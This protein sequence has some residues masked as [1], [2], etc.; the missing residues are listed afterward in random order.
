MK[1]TVIVT[2]AA[3]MLAGISSFSLAGE[4]A[5][6]SVQHEH[7]AVTSDSAQSALNTNKENTPSSQPTK[8]TAEHKAVAP[9]SMN[10][11]KPEEPMAENKP[12]ATVSDAAK[13]TVNAVSNQAKETVTESVK[14]TVPTPSLPTSPAVEAAKTVTA[15]AVPAS[16]P[17]K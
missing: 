7:S 12:A 2:A 13:S 17:T 16:T 11:K 10:E 1:R 6:K 15:P 3:L 4:E 14:S 5:K 8:T 9:T